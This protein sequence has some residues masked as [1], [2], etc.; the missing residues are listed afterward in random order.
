MDDKSEKSKR[1]IK[2]TVLL[3]LRTFFTLIIGLYTSRVVLDT[4]GVVD[5]GIY[6]V[7]G[8]IVIMFSL[9]SAS[10]SNSISRF[11]TF[12]L[13]KK[14]IRKLGIVFSTSLNIQLILSV[15]ILL[16]AEILGVWFLNVHM[17]IPAER[18]YA[19]NWVLQCSLFTFILGLISVPYNALIIAHEHMKTFAYISLIEVI[20]KLL[21]VFMLRDI[22][23]DKLIIYALF[24]AVIALI[25]R[26]IYGCYCHRNF[27]ESTYHLVFDRNILKEMSSF[28]GWYLFGTCPYV[29]NNQGINIITNIFFSVGINAARGIANQVDTAVKQFVNNFTTALNPQIIKSYA[30]GDKKYAFQ[31]VCRGAKYSYFL[32]LFFAIPCILEAGTILGLWLKEVP[33][34]TVTFMQ[35]AIF[36][37]L[38]DTPGAPLSTLALSTGNIKRYYIVI[39][40][41]GGTV[42]PISLFL[43]TLGMPA[44]VP[45]VVYLVMNVSLVFVRLVMLKKQLR[46]PITDFFRTVICKIAVVTIVAFML[47]LAFMLFIQPSVIRLLIVCTVSLISTTVS[48]SYLGMVSSERSK[49]IE[50]IVCKISNK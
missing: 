10:L 35:L 30:E 47:P 5:Y 11:I 12:E 15:I 16:L 20:L 4:L 42:F 17:N 49:M 40:A 23:Y 27:P 1:L 14:D 33:E 7:V 36:V 50:M 39:G 43:F 25:I 13:G 2:N 6:N 45:Y 48:V 31:L 44:F 34:G 28:A 46:F 8:G 26:I 3:Y 29:F 41:V 38:A 32:M 9:I 18:M 22:A 24:L 37:S 19:A 21:A